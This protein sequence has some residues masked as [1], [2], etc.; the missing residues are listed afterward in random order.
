MQDREFQSKGARDVQTAMAEKSGA[1]LLVMPTG[2][3]KTRTASLIIDDKVR[4]GNDKPIFLA[5]RRE[6]VRQTART[7]ENMLLDPGIIMAG[8]DYHRRRLVQV[9]SVDT[10][11]SWIRRGR[12][13]LDYTDTLFVD[14]AHRSMSPTYEWLINAYLDAGA[15]VLG[16][17][18][19]PIRADGVGLGRIYRH[20]IQPINM[21]QA[22]RQGWLVKPEY[23]VAYAPDLSNVRIGR[24]GDYNSSDLEKALNRKILIGDIVTNWLKHAEG[25]P[26]LAFASGVKHSIAIAEEFNAIGIKAV[27]IDGET[28]TDLRDEAI[29][30]FLRGRV[31][32]LTSCMVF[33]EGT[34]LPNVGCIIDAG[35]TKSLGKHIQKLGRGARPLYAPGFEIDT[36]EGRLA[37]IAASDKPNFVVLDH[38]GNFYRCGRVDRNINW[39]LVEGKEIVEKAREARDR[40]PVEFTCENEECNRVF[41]GQVYCPDCGTTI[42]KKGKMVDYLDA[43][44]VALTNEEFRNIETRITERDKRDF[45]LECLHWAREPKTKRRKTDPDM[46][47]RKDG[48]AAAMFKEKFGAWPPRNW[49]NMPAKQTTREVANYI[50]SR[51]I[52]HVK[53]QEK[54]KAMLN[55]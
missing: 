17:T 35:A 16:M 54:V 42:T 52:R 44:L 51:N 12:V 19:T 37:A 18:A 47:R 5:P 21:V 39:Q 3:G 38:A 50:R 29:N 46:P 24:D 36:A 31:M 28:D 41:S 6:I 20:L 10:L 7:L 33:T 48:F 13:R 22:I 9:A 40:K 53:G 25:R 27:H 4:A 11:R 45:Y 30:D 1:V 23:R 26:T 14:E 55:G 2:T 32:V 15:D 43:E 49:I 8:H 34:D